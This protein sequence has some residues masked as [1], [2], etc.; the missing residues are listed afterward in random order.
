MA[1]TESFGAKQSSVRET[2]MIE[3]VVRGLVSVQ[4][5]ATCLVWM[6]V[7][8][9]KEMCEMENGGRGDEPR[10]RILMSCGVGC[11]CDGAQL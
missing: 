2:E 7:L 11:S 5:V 8:M 10:L 4:F 3:V 1:K 6:W 9:P